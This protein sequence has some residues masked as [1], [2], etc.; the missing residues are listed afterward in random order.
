MGRNRKVSEKRHRDSEP[1]CKRASHPYA[2]ADAIIGNWRILA[3]HAWATNE[4][5]WGT[6][7]DILGRWG[8]SLFGQKRDP[9]YAAYVTYGFEIRPQFWDKRKDY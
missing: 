4:N 7:F 1:Q 2:Q 8:F 3:L 6:Y 5:S 9:N